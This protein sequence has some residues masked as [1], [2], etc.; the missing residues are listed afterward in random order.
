MEFEQ[1]QYKYTEYP[2]DQWLLL[3]CQKGKTM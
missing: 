2:L 1:F 3:D